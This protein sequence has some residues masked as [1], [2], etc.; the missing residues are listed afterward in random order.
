MYDHNH[1]KLCEECCPHAEGWFQLVTHY[2]P[3]NGQWA[4][5]AGCGHVVPEPPP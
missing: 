2:G 5:R 3:L 1:G 4:C